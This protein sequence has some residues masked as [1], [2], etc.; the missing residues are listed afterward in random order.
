MDPG[1]G[2]NR[3]LPQ[4]SVHRSWWKKA[5]SKSADTQAYKRV[6]PLSE[7]ARKTNIRDKQVERGRHSNRSIRNQLYMASS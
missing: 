7:R 1:A 4:F 5:M 2:R 3:T 6:K